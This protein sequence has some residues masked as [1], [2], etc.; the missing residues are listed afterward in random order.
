MHIPA[1]FDTLHPQRPDTHPN[2][3]DDL[4][5][6]RHPEIQDDTGFHIQPCTS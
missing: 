4:D 1:G 5:R 3:F 2:G 6:H